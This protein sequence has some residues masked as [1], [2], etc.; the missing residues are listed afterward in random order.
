MHVYVDATVSPG[1]GRPGQLK[2][3][4][5]ASFIANSFSILVVVF[6]KHYCCQLPTTP[7]P[8]PYLCR[9]MTM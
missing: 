7:L 6:R 3:K 4:L 9:N 1:E 5:P 8:P 2:E